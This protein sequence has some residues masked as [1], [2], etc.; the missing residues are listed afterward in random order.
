MNPNGRLSNPEPKN[1]GDTDSVKSWPYSYT[2]D[3]GTGAVTTYVYTIEDYPRAFNFNHDARNGVF[4]VTM[5][6]GTEERFRD[7]PTRHLLVE[8][9]PDTGEARPVAKR[10]RPAYVWLCREERER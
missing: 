9:D 6:D 7:N 8:P 10:G 1:T 4:V 5:A 2:R 3:D